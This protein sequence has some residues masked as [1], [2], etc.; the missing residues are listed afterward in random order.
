[1]RED[2]LHLD[3]PRHLYFYPPDALSALCAR[4]GLVPR[5]VSTDDRLSGILSR[6]AWFHYVRRWLPVKYVR[7]LL[8][9]SVGMLLWWNVRPKPGTTGLGSGLTAIYGKSSEDIGAR[10][11]L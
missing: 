11:P 10:G 8:G 3:A 4:F 6:N 9:L 1:M 7:D 5:F 2:W